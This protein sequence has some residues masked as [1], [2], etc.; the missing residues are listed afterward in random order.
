MKIKD[1][2]PTVPLSGTTFRHPETGE[3]VIWVSQWNRGVWFKKDADNNQVFP[4][5]V[6]NIQDAL[7]FE[8]A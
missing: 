7:E 8:V 5:P 2:K 4:L 3:K 6:E 1:L